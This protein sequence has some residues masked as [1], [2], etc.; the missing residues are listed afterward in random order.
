MRETNNE[1]LKDSYT[2][3]NESFNS[4]EINCVFATISIPQPY[5]M[6]VFFRNDHVY[7]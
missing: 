3:D 2:S 5:F 1:R 6:N 4:V 7:T